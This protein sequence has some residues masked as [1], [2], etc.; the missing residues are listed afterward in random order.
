[1]PELVPPSLDDAKARSR[2]FHFMKE[3]NGIIANKN[4]DRLQAFIFDKMVPPYSFFYGFI[5]HL[6][7]L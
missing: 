3:L 4:V 6:L 5:S 2:L 7:G 1:M